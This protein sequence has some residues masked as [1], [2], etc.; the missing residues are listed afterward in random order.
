MFIMRI[1][2]VILTILCLAY[3]AAEVRAS[4]TEVKGVVS[5]QPVQPGDY[6]NPAFSGTVDLN[7]HFPTTPNANTGLMVVLHGLGTHFHQYDT[8]CETWVNDFNVLTVQVNYRGTGNPPPGYDLGK[9]QAI[10]VLRVVQYMLKNYTLDRSRI[11]LWGASAGGNVA[12][13]T[14]KMAPGTFALVAALHPIT[15]PTNDQ[16]RVN[17]GYEN[18]PLGGWEKF[19]LGTGLS[20]TPEEWDI[21][22]AQYLA[23]YLKDVP[24]YLIHGDKDAVVDWQHSKDLYD[25]LQ[26]VGGTSTL[27]TILGGSHDFNDAK[28]PTENSRFKVTQKYLKTAINTL[29]TTGKLELDTQAKITFPT[30]GTK[31]WPVKFDPQGLATLDQVD[32][33]GAVMSLRVDT[34]QVKQG[35]SLSFGL[36][37]DN[38]MSSPQSVILLAGFFQ[39]SNSTVWPLVGPIPYLLPTTGVNGPVGIPITTAFPAGEYLFVAVVMGSTPSNYIDLD[40]FQFTVTSGS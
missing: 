4:G 9:Y 40:Y 35:E 1:T 38:W 14:A 12:L 33:P 36:K 15:R 5:T 28:D 7:I 16:D 17:L 26:N 34:P 13:H 27:I 39:I 18:D 22:D 20:Y 8:E 31:A 11:F 19:I 10:D 24:V 2:T 25:R 3:G 30:R 37:L 21:R 29:T 6:M 32:F 23:A